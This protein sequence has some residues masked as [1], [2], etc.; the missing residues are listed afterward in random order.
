MG[1]GIDIINSRVVN[2]VYSYFTMRMNDVVVFHNN[3]DMNDI[4][5]IIIKKSQV[6]GFT[7]FNKT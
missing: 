2:T 7:F 6:A 4:S 1:V 3:P 5:L